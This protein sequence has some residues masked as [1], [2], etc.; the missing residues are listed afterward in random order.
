MTTRRRIAELLLLHQCLLGCGAGAGAS[1]D[2]S[3]DAA[4]DLVVDLGHSVDVDP[5]PDGHIALDGAPPRWTQ[6]RGRTNE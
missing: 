2:A 4:A 1:P 5:P 6:P 3:D